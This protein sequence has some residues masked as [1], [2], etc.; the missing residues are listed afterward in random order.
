M[1]RGVVTQPR[2][3]LQDAE[4]TR[5]RAQQ[6][7]P[8]AALA[9]MGPNRSRSHLSQVSGAGGFPGTCPTLQIWSR[10]PEAG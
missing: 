10:G 1:E 7:I 4:C 5:T 3:E 9:S 2:S 6:R 8:G